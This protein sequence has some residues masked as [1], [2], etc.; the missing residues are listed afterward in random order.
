MPELPEVESVVRG[1]AGPLGGRT[2]LRARLTSRDL[3]RRGSRPLAGVVGSKIISVERL[4]KAILFQIEAPG[5]VLVVHLGM[6]GS[7]LLE[8][9]DDARRRR[10]HRHATIDLDDGTRV[11]YVDPRRFGFFWIGP[12]GDD[13]E[14]ELNIGPDPFQMTARELRRRLG[15]RKAPIKSLLLN[16]RLISGLG[17]IY[18]DEIL[19]YAR[20]H[21][22]TPGSATSAR[23]GVLLRQTRRILRKA[24]A[25]GGTTI[26]DYRRTD[27]SAGEFQRQLAVYGREGE[28]C[29]RCGTA[30][31]RTVVASRGTHYCPSCQE[32]T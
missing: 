26:R 29:I 23:A 21:P 22:L 8:R 4:G 25:R 3:Y 19:F 2:I 27:G 1:L 32:N 18:A 5:P 11:V 14:G 17:N 30:V 9:R 7:L 24:I 31:R 13:L 10:K 16:Q 12:G 15:R 20:I 28:P 6:T